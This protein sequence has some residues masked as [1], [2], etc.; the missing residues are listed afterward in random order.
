MAN[1]RREP[2]E[3]PYGSPENAPEMEGAMGGTSDA[4][5]AADDAAEAAELDRGLEDD[6]TRHRTRSPHKTEGA[7]TNADQATRGTSGGTTPPDSQTMS[8]NL[9]RPSTEG[10]EG[11]EERDAGWS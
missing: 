7:G 5:T 2:P 9:D 4:G 8:A 3:R 10:P 6:R 1:E 11:P